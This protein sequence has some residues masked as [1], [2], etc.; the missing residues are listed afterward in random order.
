[1]PGLITDLVVSMDDRF[2]YFSNWLHGDIR[3]YDVSD[4]AKPKLSG[5]LWI[6]GMIGKA[7]EFRGAKLRGGPQMLQLSLDGKRLYVTN[8]LQSDWDNQFY[9]D[10]AKQ[11]SHLLQ[12]DC[13]TERGGLKMNEN[14]FVDFGKEPNGPAR[15][16]EMRYPGGDCTSDIF[17]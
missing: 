10:M 5:Q 6:G 3:Q 11:G 14:F 13:D 12:I 17:T 8:S 15:A 7:P 1:V 16:H 2:L 9:P 4:P